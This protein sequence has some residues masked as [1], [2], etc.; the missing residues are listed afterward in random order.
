[1]R[2]SEVRGLRADGPG[3]QDVQVAEWREAL[4]PLRSVLGAPSLVGV[5]RSRAPGG[6]REVPRVWGMVLATS[7]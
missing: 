4:H 6:A 2:P 5:D 7:A 3:P 1:V